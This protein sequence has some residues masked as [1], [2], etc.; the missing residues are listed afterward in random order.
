MLKL[1][2][3]SDFFYDLV[4]RKI[5]YKLVFST[6]TEKKKSEM[7]LTTWKKKNCHFHMISQNI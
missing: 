4:Y 3:F 6:L 2:I 1:I 5:P 7:V